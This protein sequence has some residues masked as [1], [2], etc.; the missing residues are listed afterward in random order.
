MSDTN[1]LRQPDEDTVIS[2]GLKQFSNLPD[3]LALIK[4]Q[5]RTHQ[6]LSRDIPEI[7]DG[8]IILKKCKIGHVQYREGSWPNRCTLKYRVH[9]ETE[10]KSI[11]LNGIL[12]P[13]GVIPG[14][15]PIVEGTFGAED[16]HA[17]LPELNLE[18][19]PLESETELVAFELLTNPEKAREFLERSLWSASPS[20]HNAQIKSCNP[21][22]ARYK[23]GDRCTILYH[24]EYATD[25]SADVHAPPILVAKTTRQE[26]G[27]NA[28]AALSALWNASF[29]RSGSVRI[30]EPIAYDPDLRVFVQGPVW[31]EQTLADLFL[32]AL[33]EETPEALRVIS[34]TMQKTAEGLADLHQ[35]GVGIGQQVSWEDEMKEVDDALTPLYTVFP[36]LSSAAAPFFDKIR[37]LE[38]ETSPDPFVPSHGT[39]RPVQV[40][41]NKGEISF[42]DF[43]SFCQSEPARDLSMFLTSLMSI[44]LAPPASDKKSDSDRR[45]ADPGY[46]D[47]RFERV[48]SICDQFLAAYEQR[49]PVSRQRVALWEALNLLYFVVTGW[50]KVKTSEIALLVKLLDGFLIK[51]RLTDAG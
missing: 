49:Q 13:P 10:E 44:S 24:L 4:D 25:M 35:S 51:S 6:V 47:A 11:E 50:T 37:R 9:G 18:L 22:I 2:T 8:R 15:H 28:F 14:D 41:L 43:D 16:W 26:K 38:A 42:I 33:D 46:W 27:R 40:L 48:Y 36:D 20:Y 45:I 30:A 29:G 19:V 34:E 3:W 39:F 32:S 23:P 17:V 7:A 5:H 12:Y 1:D 31:E 21:E